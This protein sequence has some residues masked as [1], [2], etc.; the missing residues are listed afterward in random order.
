LRIRYVEPETESVILAPVD[1]LD[2][3]R[4]RLSNA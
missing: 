4:A 3:R 2:E 1:E